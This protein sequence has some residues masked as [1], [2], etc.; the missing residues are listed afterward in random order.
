MRTCACSCP[1]GD[2]DEPKPTKK[3]VAVNVS[4][5]DELIAALMRAKAEAVRLGYLMSDGDAGTS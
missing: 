4:K 5:L 2:D 3:G 1:S